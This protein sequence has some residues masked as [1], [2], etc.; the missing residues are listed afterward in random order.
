MA[1]LILYLILSKTQ[2]LNKNLIDLSK[3]KF[4]KTLESIGF[5]LI[6]ILKFAL[7]IGRF[8]FNF[9][10]VSFPFLNNV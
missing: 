10:E 5:F 9:L 2:Y 1:Y 3:I 7:L 6:P 4:K 8:C